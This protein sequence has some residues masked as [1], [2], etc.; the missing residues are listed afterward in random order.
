[1]TWEDATQLAE[2][3]ASS[4]DAGMLHVGVIVAPGDQGYA[5]VIRHHGRHEL[6]YVQS[7]DA[8]KTLCE[9]LLNP[10]GR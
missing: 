8:F 10:T 1:M 9:A 5:V 2:R 3:I 7:M 4:P 6:H